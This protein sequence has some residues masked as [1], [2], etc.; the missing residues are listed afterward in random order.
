M[1]QFHLIHSSDTITEHKT[2]KIST[3]IWKFKTTSKV[4]IKVIVTLAAW[5]AEMFLQFHDTFN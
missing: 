5:D 2:V 1:I 3:I 4:A